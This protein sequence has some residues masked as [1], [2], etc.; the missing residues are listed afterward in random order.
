MLDTDNPEV[1]ATAKC[2]MDMLSLC[3]QPIGCAAAGRQREWSAVAV[4]MQLQQGLG[5]VGLQLVE[6]MRSLVTVFLTFPRQIATPWTWICKGG[7]W[8]SPYEA[9]LRGSCSSRHTLNLRM[10]DT[11]NKVATFSEGNAPVPAITL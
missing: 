7:G 10:L 8:P 5:W 3:D 4:G 2:R 11:H 9:V 6:H 1:I